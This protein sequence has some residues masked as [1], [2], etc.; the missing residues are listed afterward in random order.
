MLR[1]GE[2]RKLGWISGTGREIVSTI[3]HLEGLGAHPAYY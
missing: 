1:V 2:K 3:T